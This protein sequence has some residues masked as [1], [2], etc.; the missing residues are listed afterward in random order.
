MFISVLT[1]AT[2]TVTT[3]LKKNLEAIAGKHSIYSL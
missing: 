2:R 1:G 3:G